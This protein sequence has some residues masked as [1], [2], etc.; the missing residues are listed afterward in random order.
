VV[1]AAA[2][3]SH[4]H[5]RRGGPRKPAR[6]RVQVFSLSFLDLLSCPLGGIL[7]LWLLSIR[8]S[9]QEAA[10]YAGQA[11]SMQRQ[12]AEALAALRTAPPKGTTGQGH[13][14]G[15]QKTIEGIKA[16]QAALIDLKRTMDGAVFG[17][18]TS[19]SEAVNAHGAFR[20]WRSAVA[21]HPSEIRDILM[22]GQ[23]TRAGG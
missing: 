2:G 13:A 8:Q 5:A 23:E 6:R 3:V 18:D 11:H 16:T 21:H 19:G 9:Q 7:V 22:Q 1:Y 20:R 4:A 10:S 17:F 14:E 15:R 12:I